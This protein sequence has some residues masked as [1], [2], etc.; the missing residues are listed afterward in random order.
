MFLLCFC[1]LNKDIIITIIIELE[2]YDKKILKLK[3]GF[4]Y[5]KETGCANVYTYEYMFIIAL[6]IFTFKFIRVPA[7]TVLPI[8]TFKFIRMLL[9]KT[10]TS[11]IVTYSILTSIT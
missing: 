4:S 1:T 11:N 8:F 5:I 9:H 6:Q 10:Y 2:Q 7:H 3:N